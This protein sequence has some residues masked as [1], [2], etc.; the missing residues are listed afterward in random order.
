MAWVLMGTAAYARV[1]LEVTGKASHAGSAPEKG[2]NAVLEL[3][4][5][6]LQTRDVAKD[7]PGAQL[8]WTNVKSD[9][10]FNRIPDYAVATGDGRI[11]VK[12][13]EADLLKALKARVASSTLIPGTTT[14]VTMEILRPGYVGNDKTRAVAVLTQE[15]D[16]EYGGRGFYIVPMIKGATDAGYAAVSGKAAVL[17]GFG[18]SG[19]NIHSKDEYVEVDSLPASIYQVARLL[20][21]LGKRHC[22]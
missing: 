20:M 6:L 1:G 22:K 9:K 21:E 13:A 14:R 2:R 19:A 11:T 3:A 18:P 16:G 4:H 15:I 10:A 12:G 5:Q 7:V 8:N 17:E